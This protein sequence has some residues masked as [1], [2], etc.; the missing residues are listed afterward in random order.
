MKRVLLVEDNESVSLSTAAVLETDG[1]DVVE[2]SSL[3]TAARAIADS[4]FDAV[5]LDRELPD[6]RGEDLLPEIRRRFPHACVIVSSGDTRSG[7][8]QGADHAVAK[9]ETPLEL[10]RLLGAF[11]S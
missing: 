4:S 3:A 9:G 2:A 7:K 5:I 6:G 8:P 1:Y 11:G 10:L